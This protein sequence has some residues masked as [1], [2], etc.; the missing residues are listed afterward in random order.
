MSLLETPAWTVEVERGPNCLFLHLHAPSEGHSDA[1]E[2]AALL[3]QSAEQHFAKNLVL[4]LSSIPS[5]KSALLGQLVLLHKRV[6]N[7]GGSLR[8]CGLTDASREALRISRLD[9]R[10][11]SYENAHDA[12]MTASRP[13]KPK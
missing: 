4:D 2:V 11:P 12:V 6:H 9:T 7:H 8:L 3:W 13:V 10:F 5:L 1:V